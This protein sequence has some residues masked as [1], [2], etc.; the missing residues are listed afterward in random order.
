MGTSCGVAL[1]VLAPGGGL[2]T[3]ESRKVGKVKAGLGRPCTNRTAILAEGRQA[4]YSAWLDHQLCPTGA[5]ALR[6]G[7]R[8]V[9][10]IG[11]DVA[12]ARLT[13][14]VP[15]NKLDP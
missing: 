6:S 8:F 15:A 4:G 1:L 10:I 14:A 11:Q 12:N 7:Q 9:G 2:F 5:P 3:S 13:L